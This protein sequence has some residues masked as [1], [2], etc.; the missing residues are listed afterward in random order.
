VLGTDPT[1]AIYIFFS[2]GLGMFLV[3]PWAGQRGY[4]FSRETLIATGLMVTGLALV[5]LAVVT[6]DGEVVVGTLS[7]PSQRMII[8]IVGM[9]IVLGPA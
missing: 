8:Q 6:W 9:A 7:Q 5:G 1:D 2:A 4:R 3:T